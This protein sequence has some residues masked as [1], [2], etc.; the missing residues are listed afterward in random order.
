MYICEHCHKEFKEDFRRGSYREPPRFCSRA[1]AN[2]RIRTPEIKE[3]ISKSINSSNK[4]KESIQKEKEKRQT[5]EWKENHRLPRIIKSCPVCGKNFECTVK[6]KKTY[7]SNECRLRMSGGLRKGS[8]RSKT[9]YYKGVYC[10][11]TYELCWVIYNLEHNISF[12]KSKT[13]I[14]YVYQ[15]KQ[16]IYYP[17]FELEDGTLIEIKGYYT[18]QAKAKIDAA[19]SLGYTIKILYEKDL[20][21]MFDYVKTKYKTSDFAKLYDSSKK[22]YTYTCD[23]CG[24]E[25]K[26]AKEAKTELKFCSR[27]CSGKYISKKYISKK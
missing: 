7:C 13:Q 8:G 23:Y 9:G 12:K 21:E 1:C 16:H 5:K 6:D 20:K 2:S 25:F 26:R 11:S 19:E 18:D 27:N 17:D 22:I 15:D 3:K 24:K 4:F 10:G 14:P